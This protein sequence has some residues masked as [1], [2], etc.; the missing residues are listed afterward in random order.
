[1]KLCKAAQLCVYLGYEVPLPWCTYACV[2]V[3]VCGIRTRHQKRAQLS[4]IQEVAKID[5]PYLWFLFTGA[6]D[7]SK[8]GFVGQSAV[9]VATRGLIQSLVLEPRDEYGNMCARMP[10]TDSKSNYKLVLKQVSG[11]SEHPSSR[12]DPRGVRKS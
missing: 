1:M 6:L 4:R 3:W 5:P 2:W 7:P 8:T 10:E 9:V 11:S 12:P